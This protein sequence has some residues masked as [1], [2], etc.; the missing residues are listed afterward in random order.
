[1]LDPLGDSQLPW[2]AAPFLDVLPVWES[3]ASWAFEVWQTEV[4]RSVLAEGGG[5]A[6]GFGSYPINDQLV[7]DSL[8]HAVLGF[9]GRSF[10]YV[11]RYAETPLL[12]H[13]QL[14]LQPMRHHGD[15]VQWHPAFHSAPVLPLLPEGRWVLRSC[16]SG[17]GG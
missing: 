17:E 6:N 10:P 12:A 14:V 4:F 11:P 7:H 1:M 15:A 13:P 8:A 16:V 9:Q 5:P 2:G 3:S